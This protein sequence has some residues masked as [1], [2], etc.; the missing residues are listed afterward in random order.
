MDKAQL[1]RHNM[2]RHHE[3]SGPPRPV[4]E[5]IPTAL[6]DHIK[7]GK[8]FFMQAQRKGRNLHKHWPVFYNWPN[9]SYLQTRCYTSGIPGPL[10][11]L[12]IHYGV[13]RSPPI[14]RPCVT[15]RNKV[16]SYS[17]QLLFPRPTPKVEGLSGGNFM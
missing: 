5:P 1:S 11:N 16:V 6:S 13:H 2:N 12:K 17:E 10:W 15:F 9:I 8:C 7:N 14:P 3:R 4:H